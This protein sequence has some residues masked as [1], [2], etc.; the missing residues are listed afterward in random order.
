MTSVTSEIDFEKAIADLPKLSQMT[1]EK[2]IKLV[3]PLMTQIVDPEQDDPQ[4]RAFVEPFKLFQLALRLDPE[5]KDAIEEHRKIEGIFPNG[6]EEHL[7]TSDEDSEEE[8]PTHEHEYDVIVVGAGAAGIGVAISLTKT[9]GLSNERVL[10]LERGRNIGETFLRWPDEMRFISPSFNSQ[11]WTGSF[12]L[13]SVAYGT[14]PAYTLQ[15]EH[16]SGEQYAFYLEE[17]A[18]QAKLNVKTNSEVTAVKSCGD[19]TEGFFVEAST[20]V[21]SWDPPK[22]IKYSTRYVIW[23]AGEYQYPSQMS[24][25]KFPGAE[26]CLHNSRVQTWQKLKGGNNYIVIGGYESGCDAAYNLSMLGKQCTVVSS[27]ACWRV[28]TDDPSTELAPYTADRLRRAC[29]SDAPPRLL[30]PL[31]VFKVER[32]TKG[33]GSAVSKQNGTKKQKQDHNTEEGGYI[34]HARWG[35]EDDESKHAASR[36]EPG[37]FS[38]HEERGEEGTEIQL[39]TPHAPLLCTGFQGSIIG[40]VAKDLFSWKDP[41]STGDDGCLSSSPLLSKV[42]ES[43]KTPGLFLVGPAVAHGD[44]VFCF[45]Y[46]YRQRFCVVAD[47]ICRGLGMDTKKAVKA[48]RDMNMF[49]DDFSCCKGACG[50]VC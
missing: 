26:L 24:A 2:G 29:N 50:N 34:V 6:I 25:G 42:D 48:A 10:I 12:D 8:E 20:R 4:P 9:F 36:D 18:T 35:N 7:E 32:D 19:G 5:N 30:A 11:G 27:T 44:L 43:T 38:E 33:K 39:R 40:G 3:K 22:K 15:A 47:A 1:V 41:N 21:Q 13:N 45:V 17:L 31:R 23:A 28:V 46:K 14:S 49:L 16:P 37:V